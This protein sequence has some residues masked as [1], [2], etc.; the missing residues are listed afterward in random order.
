MKV[1]ILSDFQICISVPLI[2]HEEQ[3]KSPNA[4]DGNVGLSRINKKLPSFDLKD[5]EQL[6]ENIPIQTGQ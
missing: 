2:L 5:L 4:S 6:T 3:L 1:E